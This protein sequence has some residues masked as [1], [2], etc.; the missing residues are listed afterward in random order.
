MKYSVI[1]PYWNSEKWLKRCLD[2]LL[3]QKG[4]FEFLIVNDGSTDNGEQIAE[5]YEAKDKRFKTYY[6]EREKGVSGARNTGL[7][8]ATGDWI[9]FLDADDELLPDAYDKFTEEIKIKADIHQFNHLRYYTQ[10]DTTRLKYW[11]HEG[12]YGITKLPECWYGVWNKLFSREL[13]IERTHIRFD[14]TL[15]YGEDGLFALQCIGKAKT[16]HHADKEIVTVRHRFDNKESL[17]HKK[18]TDDLMKQIR[19]YEDFAIRSDDEETRVAMCNII[20]ELWASQRV[21][22]L[23]GRR[24]R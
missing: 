2:S 9:T 13:V 5:E 10:I 16:L 7:S 4:N 1:V 15:Q 24:K 23:I 6:N 20:S 14:E 22:N 12:W 18:T 17:S 19:T 3:D 8:H 21:E 11:N